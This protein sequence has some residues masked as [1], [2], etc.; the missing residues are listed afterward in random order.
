MTEQRNEL[1]KL[2]LEQIKADARSGNTSCL[3]SLLENIDNSL[4]E[5]YLDYNTVNA[6]WKKY[7]V[8]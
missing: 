7:P 3:E 6:F 1:V 8:S 5:D 4:L 2:V